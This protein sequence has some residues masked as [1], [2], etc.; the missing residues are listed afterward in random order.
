MNFYISYFADSREVWQFS[1]VQPDRDDFI[2]I[3]KIEDLG[4][5]DVRKDCITNYKVNYDSL[6]DKYYI[7]S[8]VDVS[9]N[10]SFFE[11]KESN[12]ADI[13]IIQDFISHKWKF[14]LSDRWQIDENPEKLYFSICQNNNPNILIRLIEINFD[15]LYYSKE[16]LF[17]FQYEIENDKEKISIFTHYTSI[18]Y[19]YKKNYE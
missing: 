2:V 7:T 14:I 9:K 4:G 1:N 10:T 16:I 12:Y 11:I 13:F 15:T 8:K 3:N 19:S 18:N 5:L 17:P 6:F